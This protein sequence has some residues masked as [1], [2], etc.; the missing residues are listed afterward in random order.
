MDANKTV[1]ANFNLSTTVPP[2]TLTS[3]VITSPT[4]NT[5]LPSNTTSVT[6]TWTGD[7]SNYLVRYETNGANAVL[8]NTYTAK[9]YTIPVSAGKSYSFWVHTGTLSNYSPEARINFSV[10]SLNTTN[11]TLTTSAT[12]GSIT[13]NTNTYTSGA[14]ATLT[15]VPNTGY[16]FSSWTGCTS[17][18][19]VCTVSM[20]SN[21]TVTAN[22]TQ[23]LLTVPPTTL[24]SPVITSPTN[25][26]VLPSNTTSVTVSWTGDASNY[27]VRVADQTDI[28]KNTLNNRTNM[29]Y[30]NS[31]KTKSITF[32][33][34]KGHSYRFWVHT[35]TLTNYSPEAVINFSV[36]LV[37]TY[38]LLTSATNGSITGSTNTYTSGATA[39]LTAVPNT[40]YTFSSWTGCTSSTNVCTVSMTSNKTVTANFTAIPSIVT[41]VITSPTNNAVLPYNTTSVTVN[42]TGDATNYLYRVTDLT[43]AKLN[44]QKYSTYKVSDTY[45]SK[46]VTFPVVQGHSYRFWV[47]TGTLA[48]YSPEAAINFS[49]ANPVTTITWQTVAQEDASFTVP[50]N[51]VVR[52]GLNNSWIQKTVSG[53]ATCSNTFFGSDP[54]Y[55]VD[56]VCQKQVVTI[57]QATNQTQFSSYTDRIK[58]IAASLEAI[59]ELLK[60][61]VR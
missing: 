38:T 15:A 54:I 57:S 39:T 10:A 42:W 8:V 22:F 19:N 3:P 23:I 47:H 25:N 31:Y 46:T 40:G 55:G 6:V 48:K 58:A 33:V 5:V 53:T 26:T 34:I 2:T 28:T 27:L 43:D 56:K 24:T 17:S 32:S 13:G 36:A 49:V 20:T 30:E 44:T 21:K 60:N 16:T 4:N 1:T 50:T 51:T 18:T 41:P 9:S 11:Y 61:F 59:K 29:V 12:N 35:G 14:T 37:D 52:Y 7:A 45:T